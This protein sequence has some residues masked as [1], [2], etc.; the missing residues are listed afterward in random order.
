MAGGTETGAADAR[1][2]V[3]VAVEAVG[4]GH[5][6]PGRGASD[7]VVLEGIDLRLDAGERIA[8]TGRSSFV[9]KVSP[10][11]QVYL[12]FTAWGS[13]SHRYRAVV[14]HVSAAGQLANLLNKHESALA[15]IETNMSDS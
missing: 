1:P 9:M 2:A 6:Y 5:T 3:G 13:V 7:V 12:G 11:G 14:T 8:V 4:I 15:A 10:S